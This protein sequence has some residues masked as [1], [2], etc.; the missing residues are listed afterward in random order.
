[1]TPLEE[2][3]RVVAANNAHFWRGTNERTSRMTTGGLVTITETLAHKLIA[4]LERAAAPSAPSAT[5][6]E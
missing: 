4:E 3:R 1:M 6:A 5:A 2:L